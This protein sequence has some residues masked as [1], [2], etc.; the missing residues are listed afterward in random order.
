MSD[1]HEWAVWSKHVLHEL[2]RLNEGQDQIKKDIQ[3][4]KSDLNRIAVL[5]DQVNDIKAWKSQVTEVYS[6]TQLAE[7]KK[8]VEQLKSFKIK[9]VTIWAVIQFVISIA[10]ALLAMG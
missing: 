4:L 5:E 3:T 9:F 10:L 6:P 2:E 8:E 7:Q 1:E